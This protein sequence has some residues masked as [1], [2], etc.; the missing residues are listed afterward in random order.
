[1]L[2]ELD[3]QHPFHDGTSVTLVALVVRAGGVPAVPPHF[4]AVAAS[5]TPDDGG[6]PAGSTWPP[7]PFFPRLGRVTVSVVAVG[8]TITDGA[9]GRYTGCM[10]VQ[11]PVRLTERDVAALDELVSSGRFANRSD[12]LRAGLARVIREEREREIDE[13]YRRGYGEHPQEEWIGRAGLAAFAA[14]HEA[15][16]GE[17]L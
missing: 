6:E 11:V 1:M 17:P 5:F 3:R 2:R 15:E 7:W 9:A 14:F 4:A 13:A 16:G 8:D 10:T 12:V